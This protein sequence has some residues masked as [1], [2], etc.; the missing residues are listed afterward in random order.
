MSRL[1]LDSATEF[2]FGSSVHSLM[3]PLP[4][5]YNSLRNI[6]PTTPHP[7]SR[8][9]MAFGEAQVIPTLRSRLGNIWPLAEIFKEKTKAHMAIINEY[10]DPII[11]EALEK[12]RLNINTHKHDPSAPETLLDHLVQ[13]TDGIFF[14]S[15]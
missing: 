7:S 10:I 12:K 1:T 11:T 4:Y 5:A 15:S 9:A 3:A 6:S 14:S 2:L 13:K 8:F